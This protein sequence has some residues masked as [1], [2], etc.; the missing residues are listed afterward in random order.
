MV[1]RMTWLGK[2]VTQNSV[3]LM[4]KV[5]LVPVGTYDV[6][7]AL[8]V[9]ADALVAGGREKLFT[10]M[11]GSTIHFFSVSPIYAN[12]LI[13]FS[14]IL[15]QSSLSARSP[16]TPTATSRVL[17]H[18]P[19]SS[20]SLCLLRLVSSNWVFSKRW[21]LRAALSHY[22]VAYIVLWP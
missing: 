9:A 14:C 8:K 22:P 17:P 3:W 4:E 13:V 7:E 11:R 6:G 12:M 18:Q 15:H 16:S 20:H 21:L 2:V 19:I 5:G 10:P 1:A